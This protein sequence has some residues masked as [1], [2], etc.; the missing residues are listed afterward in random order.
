MS[1]RRMSMVEA[2]REAIREE[3]RRDETVFVLGE[4]VGIP[5]G[6]GGAFTVTLGLSDE[7]GHQR[8][9]DTPISEAGI[10]GLAIGAAISGLRPILDTQYSDFLFCMADQLI[11]QAG[12][13][14]Y[15]SGGTVQVPI[16][17]RSAVGASGRGAQHGQVPSGFFTHAPGW[18]VVTPGTPYDAK[19]LLK[20]AVRSNNPVI[21]FEHKKL[22]AAKGIR[23]QPGSLTVVD[24][25]PDEDYAIPF[26]Q[27]KISRPGTDVT[28]VAN[29]LMLHHALRAAETLATEGVSAEVID[30]RTLVPFD[31]DTVVSSVRKTG[32]LIL[33][34]EDNRT[35]SWTADIAAET[36]TR[37]FDYMDSPIV[38][39]T[40]PDTPVPFAPPME[41]FYVPSPERIATAVRGILD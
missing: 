19:G 21:V 38:R 8:I 41:G 29:L 22:Y 6:F 25:I 3:M 14:S 24:D 13:L 40:A 17:V 35:G 7:F 31:Y 34:D 11:N 36:A 20:T 9:L 26:G 39:V 1:N 18:Q 33:V 5:K 32:H 10:A 28:I 15:M 12:K 16:V 37:A 4:D 23:S 2:L 27:A 30:P